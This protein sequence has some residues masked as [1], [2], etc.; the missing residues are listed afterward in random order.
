MDGGTAQKEKAEEVK[1]EVKRAAARRRGT[2]PMMEVLSGV[3]AE[4]IQFA[5]ASAGGL[6]DNTGASKEVPPDIPDR[7]LH[8]S[9]ASEGPLYPK[10]SVASASNS[11]LGDTEF[12]RKL[13]LFYFDHFFPFLFPF[14]QPSLLEGG[15]S[16]IIELALGNQV[17]WH[18][19][20][21][22]STYFFSIAL[23][24]AAQGHKPCK[25]M[26]WD[27]LLTQTG[28]TFK[29][30]QRE[31][32]DTDSMGSQDFIVK[33]S[34]IM[35]SIIQVQRFEISVGNFENC[36]KHLDAATTLLKQIFGTVETELGHSRQATLHDV[37]SCLGRPP[38]GDRF[39]EFGAWS[40]DQAAF[41]FYAALLLVDD[42]LAS[43][44]TEEPPK[45]IEYH[46]RLLGMDFR[47][48][49][50][51]ILLLSDF[52]GCENWVMLHISEIS[53]LDRWKKAMKRAAQLDMMELVARASS[54]RQAL[55]DEISRLNTSTNM[56]RATTFTLFSRYSDHMPSMPGSCTTFVT[57]LW[58][59]GAL[60][61][62]SLV[63]FG[64]QPGSVTIQER[65]KEILA[66]LE[67]MTAPEM[68][69]TVVWPFCLAGC[70][71]EPEQENRF[72]TLAEALRPEQL[73]GAARK[74]LHIMENVWKRR[75]E[76]TID[77]D[78]AACVGNVSLLV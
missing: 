44:C 34:R 2:L 53:A 23:D 16:W 18:T 39:Q 37:L 75:D 21:C 58:A 31:L 25:K 47:L 77:T 3:A 29:I 22:L 52:I 8:L 4:P 68:L 35:E 43:T 28:S 1:R 66:L 15:R 67:Q 74:A 40:S 36:Q 41:R 11:I 48:N 50:T 57:R 20:L 76:L 78:F 42:I 19:T 51:P 33:Q 9:S 70:L 60:L 54:I 61:Y 64:R 24:A 55:L 72:R 26:A 63:A 45:L 7:S 17:M 69:R 13:M 27:K 56:L 12:D 30:L 46:A 32:E 62:L 14:Y 73:F 59:H 38:W 5:G 49:E 10:P 65:V 71:A 6:M